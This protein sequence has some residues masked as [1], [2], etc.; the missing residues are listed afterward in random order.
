M[1]TRADRLVLAAQFGQNLTRE[2]ENE[3]LSVYVLSSRAEVDWRVIEKTERG[4]RL[5]RLGPAQRLANALE[6]E[7]DELIAGIEWRAR[8]GAFFVRGERVG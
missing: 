3:G 6:V 7:L 8:D 1:M 4:Q 2:R 5:P